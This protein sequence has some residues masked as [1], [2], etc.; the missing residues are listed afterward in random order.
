MKKLLLSSFLMFL[1]I[2][3]ILAQ[4]R[5]VSGKV[6]AKEDQSPLPGVNIV[7]KGSA[8][9][10]ITDIE[11]N[12][13][14]KVDENST[15][16]FS[17]VGF[18]NQEVQVGTQS[19]INV[20]LAS[21]A[22]QL[23]EV[24]ITG[25][26][27]ATDKRKIAIS[28]ESVTADKMPSVPNASVDQALVGKIAGAQIQSTNGTPGAQMNILLRGINSVNRGTQPMIMLDG[29]QV[30]ATDL[31]SLDLTAIERVEVVQGAAAAT[32]YGA[33]GANG[34]IQLFSKKGKAGQLN[35]DISSSVSNNEY[36]N[37]GGVKKADLHGFVTNANGEVIGSSGNAITF[38]TD[39]NTFS[40]NVIFRS[41]DVETQINK[42]YDKNLKYYDHFAMLFKAAQTYNNSIAISGGKDKFNFNISLSNN[43]QGSNIRDNGNFERTNFMSNL[44]IEVFKG[45]TLQSTTQLVYTKN[46]L[47]WSSRDIMFATLNTRPFAN[48]ESKDKDGN[49]GAYFGDA[50]G[51]N[52]TN[53]LY[54]TQYGDKLDTKIDVVQNLSAN[55]KVNK[56][57]ELDAKYGLNYQRQETVRINENESL[58]A[59]AQQ[60]GGGYYW[61]YSPDFNGE[62]I[63]WSY[64]TTFQNFLAK[65]IISTDFKEDFGLDIPIVTSTQLAFDY[66]RTDYSRY[67]TYG[68]GLPTYTPYNGSQA[69]T[70]RIEE[71]YKEPFVTYGY[72]FNQR[73]DYG[74]LLGVSAGFRTDYSSAFGQG[75]T[76]FTF[77]R[78]DGYIRPSTLDFWK[79][80]KLGEIIPEFKLRAAYGEAGIQ[81]KPFD[82]Y[83][84]L[85]TR[86][87]GSQ[88]VFYL[89][90]AQSNPD[91]SVEVSRELE[92][93]ADFS[94]SLL[95]GSE[96]LS[97]LN[98]ATT[99][100]KRNTDNAIWDVDAAPSTGIGTIKDNAFSLGSSGVQLSLNASIF[101]NKDITWNFTYNIGRQSSEITA[102]KGPQIV[103]TS[104]A[105][106]TNYVLK[107]GQKIGQLFG[108]VSL[109]DVN[110]INPNT[111]QPFIPVAEQGN[112]EVASNGYVVDKSTKQP[113]FSGDQFSFG[114]PNPTFNSSFINDISYKDFLTLGFQFDWVYG[115]HLYNQT[116]EWMYRDGIHPDYTKPFTINGETGAWSAFYRG[117]YAQRAF[118]GTKDYFYEDASFVR[119]RNVSIGVDI[120]KLVDLKG[121]KRLQLVLAG[122]NLLTWTKYTGFDPEISS[123]EANSA[124]DRGTD[125]NTMPNLRSYQVTLNVGF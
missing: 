93:G 23:S 1:F 108:F 39:N 118:N 26:G 21:D 73:I 41:L 15:L 88:N 54:L 91:L 10:T 124:W 25:V 57:I 43:R 106:S 78:A 80:G 58:N 122:R 68:L 61:W 114:D 51:V 53:P 79:D 3:N 101:K 120:A 27:T 59:N 11:G 90:T 4:S 75:S 63:N 95:K 113:Y 98:I 45:F 56:F 70:Y 12:Y 71:D 38:D 96:W 13:Q 119:L 17:F 8:T 69:G 125:H 6:T 116:K 94:L 104:N 82:R 31:N 9:G 99:Y 19:T 87:L 46:S 22:K 34:V 65:A 103:V 28:V 72:L 102:V 2:G 40:E 105:G 100:W 20:E 112:Y 117:V 55:Y 50:A 109:N 35:I 107:P 111:G 52:G 36:L 44:G 92:I 47:T 37:I 110:Q 67:V 121:F 81:P 29:V 30:A 62:K 33:Q 18:I 97:S 74:D 115:S 42:P 64:N 60:T 89:P 84:T 24:V 5:T 49:Y 77:P 14:L 48:F 66:R 7:V 85:S 76:P 83:V 86:T 16:V 123:G 32:I